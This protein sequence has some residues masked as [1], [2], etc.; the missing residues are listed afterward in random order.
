MVYEE[1][2]KHSHNAAFS[3]SESPRCQHPNISSCGCNK[4]G[5][6]ADQQQHKIV[7]L[8]LPRTNSDP[9]PQGSARMCRAVPH[10]RLRGAPSRPG[11]PVPSHTHTPLQGHCQLLPDLPLQPPPPADGQGT[12]LGNTVTSF[13][14]A[15]AAFICNV[16]NPKV[17]MKLCAVWLTWLSG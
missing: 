6:H 5:N 10:R 12:F 17:S 8:Q 16:A 7:I 11:G 3:T 9:V 1:K 14:G 15:V 4:W 2:R 13:A